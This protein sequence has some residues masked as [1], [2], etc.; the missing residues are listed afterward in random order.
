M[1]SDI[2]TS[3]KFTGL[4]ESGKFF[5]LETPYGYGGP[6][7]DSPIPASSQNLFLEEMGLYANSHGIISQFVRFHPLLM[8]HEA[9]PVVFETRYLHDTIYIDTESPELIMNNM[10][11]K[12]RNMVRKAAKSGVTI[13]RKPI[14]Q[15]QEFIPIYVETMKKDL[16]KKKLD[17]ALGKIFST[18]IGQ[19]SVRKVLS[20]LFFFTS[21]FS[22]TLWLFPSH[23][24]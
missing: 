14:E 3:S 4:L 11:S 2:S 21:I 13:E 5:D 20:S 22:L 8:N 19:L 18:N 17:N 24:R 23:S 15:Y 1:L 6:L 12:N 10:D 7:F 16:Q 9:M